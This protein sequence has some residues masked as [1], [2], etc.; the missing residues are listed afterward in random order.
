MTEGTLVRWLVK[1]GQLLTLFILF[2]HDV[3]V[4]V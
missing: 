3:K 2:N 1:E 4:T